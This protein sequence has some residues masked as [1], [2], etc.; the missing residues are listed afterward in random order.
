MSQF[1]ICLFPNK[2]KFFKNNEGILSKKD[3]KKFKKFQFI[4]KT[5][6]SIP[7]EFYFID[8]SL[9][10]SKKQK[11]GLY[12]YEIEKKVNIYILPKEFFRK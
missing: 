6:P 1:E 5:Y 12:I 2:I 10:K 11:F 8:K 4:K 9:L 3:L 7:I